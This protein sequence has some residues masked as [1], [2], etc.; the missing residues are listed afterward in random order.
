MLELFVERGEPFQESTVQLDGT[1]Y[2][3]R[4]RYS[5]REDR[6][7]LSLYSADEV[8]IT[9]GVKVVC[10]FP[11]VRNNPEGAPPGRFYAI[12]N[13]AADDSPPGLDELGTKASGAR[14]QLL[15]IPAAELTP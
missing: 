5:Q 8:P 15:Y 13:E 14:V 9:L 4:V 2:I 3:L 1:D 11:L 10:Y 6:F 7:Y 12:S